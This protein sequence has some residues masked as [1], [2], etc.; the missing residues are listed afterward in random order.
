MLPPIHFHTDCSQHIP[1]KQHEQKTKHVPLNRQ[2][3][4]SLLATKRH[5]PSLP[6]DQFPDNLFLSSNM[7]NNRLIQPTVSHGLMLASK[8]SF[9]LFAPHTR[10]ALPI[11]QISHSSTSCIIEKVSYPLFHHQIQSE[12][13]TQFFP[14]SFTHRSRAEYRHEKDTPCNSL[15]RGQSPHVSHI[16]ITKREKDEQNSGILVILP[17]K[18]K[19]LLAQVESQSQFRQC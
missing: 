6:P 15:N 7:K 9:F 10:S 5:P 17:D 11:G 13:I 14:S 19:R 18:Q 1:A 4:D 3:L 16:V 2:S 8:A 12:I